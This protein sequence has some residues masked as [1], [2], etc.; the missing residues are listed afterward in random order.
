VSRAYPRSRRAYALD[1]R[2]QDDKEVAVK[3]V[4]VIGALAIGALVALFGIK[5]KKAREGSSS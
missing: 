3:L 4:A 1:V 5:H 2:A